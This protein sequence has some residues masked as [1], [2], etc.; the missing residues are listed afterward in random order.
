MGEIMTTAVFDLETVQIPVEGV[1]AVDKIHCIAIKI[2]DS[3]TQIYTSHYL[4]GSSGTLRN[5]LEVLNSVDLVIAHNGIGFDCIVVN[6]ILG[7]LHTTCLDTMLLA[8]LIYT[9]DELSELDYTIP[10]FN[11]SKYGSF[12]LEAFGDRMQYPK[13]SHSDWSKLNTSMMSYC[14]QD[15][16]VTY[17]LYQNLLSA[18]NFPSQS[19]IDLEH[20]VAQLIAQQVHYGFYYDIDAGRSLMQKLMHEQLSISMRL[21]RTFKP[22]I[23]RKGPDV[24]PAKPRRTKQYIPDENYQYLTAIAYHPF[25][26][27]ILKNGK[28]RFKKYAWFDRPHRIVYTHYSG[29][30]YTPVE[31]TKFD[32]GS[33]HKI[34]HWLKQQYDFEFSTYTDKG[35][36]KVDG[37]EL[38]ALG[39]YGADLRRYLKIVKDLSQLR[40]LNEAVRYDSTI[41]SRIDTN[42]TVTGRFTSSSVNLNQIPAAK[43][44]RELFTAPEGWTFVGTD[45]GGQENVNLA[46]ALYE[47]D[48]GRLNEINTS[49][50][51]DL[52]TDLHSLNAKSC[53]VSRTDAKPLWF[54]FLYGSSSTLTGYTLLGRKDFTDYTQ[55]EWNDAVS[56]IEGRLREA[57]GEYYYPVKS[58]TAAVYVKYDDQLVKQAIFGKQV[59][60]RLIKSTDGLADLIKKLTNDAKQSGGILTLGGRLIPVDSPHKCLNYFCQGQGAE[61]MKNYLTIIHQAFAEAG[62]IHGEH[63][64]QQATIYDEVDF[65]VRDDCVEAVKNILQ[66]SYAKV[67]ELLGMK[68]TYTGEVLSGRNWAE[69]H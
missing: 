38:T 45:F 28:I 55:S 12:S 24:T 15:V 5:A 66:T 29:G 16:D 8:K 34:R 32:P 37:E 26:Y 65:I 13:G 17:Q 62:L 3:P 14:I 57:D 67:S 60:D 40:G 1:Y 30:D 2:D 10:D 42:G 46:E 50:D 41:T 44:F 51:K 27:T 6:N 23:L 33:R 39:D 25:Q 31:L 11:K 52:G 22:L 7:T 53:G 64:K 47:F 61:A 4:P 19:V 59:Q 9:K 35:T 69:C 68:C 63:F 20:E 36:A 43:E 21:S 49:G 56:S 58:G 18:K 54:G 48:G